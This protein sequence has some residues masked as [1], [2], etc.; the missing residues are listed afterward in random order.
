MTYLCNNRDERQ[1]FSLRHIYGDCLEGAGLFIPH[2]AYAIIDSNADIK[3]GDLVHCS[4]MAGAI[5]TF[6]KQV[7]E[8]KGDSIIVGTCYI[9]KSKDF[10]FEA[11]EIMGVVTEVYDKLS[12]SRIYVRKG[13]AE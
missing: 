12:G 4:R 11:G 9:D 2:T 3:I 7:K 6:I 13:G 8:V 10:E 5:N 1:R